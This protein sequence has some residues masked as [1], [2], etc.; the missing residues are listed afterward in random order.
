MNLHKVAARSDASEP[1]AEPPLR[2]RTF[3]EEHVAGSV[4]RGATQGG[5]F[6]ADRLGRVE[7]LNAFAER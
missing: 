4:A 1:A 2:K 5:A 3:R 6:V 7:L